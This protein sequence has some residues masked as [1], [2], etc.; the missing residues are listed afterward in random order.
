LRASGDR[1][2]VHRAGLTIVLI[3]LAYLG[4]T[5][6][7]FKGAHGAAF[8]ALFLMATA[9]GTVVLVRRLPRPLGWLMCIAL[10]MFSAWQFMWPY[11][12]DHGAPA[13]P[14]FAASRWD[15]LHKAVA[16][17]GEG[18]ETTVLYET[19]PLLYLN[20]STLAFQDYVEG[21]I[22][23]R[24]ATGALIVD[25]EQQRQRLA[26]A[27]IVSVPTPDAEDVFDMLPTQSSA[28]RAEMIKLIESTGRFGPAIRIADPQ[29]GGAVLF[30]KALPS[31]G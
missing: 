24:P 15:I 5:I 30:Y 23:P 22:P 10:L 8:A 6:P 28:F 7:A 4:V 9:V 16:A 1:K 3:V 12:R 14:A 20:Y 21:R 26:T 13:D 18:T 11:T 27:D 19:T 2:A 25:L 31:S 17:L 29:R